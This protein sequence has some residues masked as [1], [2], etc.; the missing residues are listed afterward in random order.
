M[1]Y[2]VK[3]DKS[4]RLIKKLLA[5]D[6]DEGIRIEE[7][8]IQGKKMFVNK[9]ASG[10]FVVQLVIKNKSCDYDSKDVIYFDSAEEVVKFINLTFQSRYSIMEY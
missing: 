9:N 3:D 2:P 1:G 5:L 4:K 8:S 6:I 7:S 10:I